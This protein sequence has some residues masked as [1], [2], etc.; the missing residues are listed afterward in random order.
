M[1]DTITVVELMQRNVRT[2]GADANMAEVVVALAD[3]HVV[4]EDDR[5]VGVVS[6]TDIVRGVAQG[7]N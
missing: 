6:T 3:A 4:T 1:P 5:I 2:V 7:R